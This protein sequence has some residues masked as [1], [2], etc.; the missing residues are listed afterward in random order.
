MIISALDMGPED[1]VAKLTIFRSKETIRIF[2]KPQQLG[3]IQAKRWRAPRRASSLGSVGALARRRGARCQQA[4]D[5]LPALKI[6]LEFKKVDSNHSAIVAK[7][8]A[9]LPTSLRA[10]PP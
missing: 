3:I 4:C 5:E 2:K 7:P 10:I 9:P 8:C 6:A 1:S